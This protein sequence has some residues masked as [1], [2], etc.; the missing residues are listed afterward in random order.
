[1]KP[2]HMQKGIEGESTKVVRYLL[3]DRLVSVATVAMKDTF[4]NRTGGS[5]DE[6]G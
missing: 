2:M 5:S 3:M 4:P 6:R 1:M